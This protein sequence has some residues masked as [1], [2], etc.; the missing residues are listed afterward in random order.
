[1][2]YSN[3]R[4]DRKQ[5]RLERCEAKR[6]DHDSVLRSDATEQRRETPK[7]E[8]QPRL[9]IRDRLDKLVL[10]PNLRLH[11]ILVR[12]YTLNNTLSLLLVEEVCGHRVIG[13][14]EIEED[15]VHESEDRACD[16]EPLPLV[17]LAE[18]VCMVGTEGKEGRDDDCHT[19][20]LEGPGEDQR[21]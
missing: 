13:E 7:Q 11:T 1:M 9:H 5:R 4:W 12:P 14:E 6:L 18:R 8:E 3:A 20:A 15:K 21:L 17:G 19:I 10:L 16:E 2:T